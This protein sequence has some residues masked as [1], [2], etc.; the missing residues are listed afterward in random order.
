MQH[1]KTSC[2]LQPVITNLRRPGHLVVNRSHGQMPGTPKAKRHTPLSRAALTRI[3]GAL[4]GTSASQC[5]LQPG[6][7]TALAHRNSSSMHSTC[8]S[9]SGACS[10]LSTWQPDQLIQLPTELPQPNS[11]KLSSSVVGAAKGVPQ[12]CVAKFTRFR[13]PSRGQSRAHQLHDTPPPASSSRRGRAPPLRAASE[14][15]RGIFR[16]RH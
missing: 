13:T 10:V 9:F 1:L 14:G 11:I 5:K 8:R 4:P 15:Q 2:K 16:S 12:A 3:Q 7:S 6:C